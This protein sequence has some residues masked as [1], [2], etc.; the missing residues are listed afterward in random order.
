M[1]KNTAG[2][3]VYVRAID[4]DGAAVTSD[5]AAQI[6]KDG[7]AAASVTATGTHIGNGVWWFALSQAETN[8]DMIS[9]WAES[10]AS[11]EAELTPDP[12]IIQTVT[13]ADFKAT[14]FSTHS[15]A[16]VW[17][18][19][20]RTL[21]SFGTL[22]SDV[23]TAVWSAAAR[24]LTAFGFTVATDTDSRNASK[25]DVSALAL[26]TTAQ[27]VKTQT[28]KI[29]T[30][31]EDVSGLR[32][33]AKALEEAPGGGGDSVWSTGQRDQVLAD[34]AAAK[35]AAEALP[36][37]SAIDTELTASHGAGLWTSSAMG[38]GDTLFTYTVTYSDDVTPIPDVRVLVSTD[39]A[40]DNLIAS[41]VTNNFGE[42]QFQLDAGTYYFWKR[43]AGFAF[44]EVP[45][46]VVVGDSSP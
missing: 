41:G 16:D 21:S 38:S 28:D 2:Q 23:T 42:V 27:A 10:D 14:G 12:V 29:G 5:I 40:R 33:T 35:T 3:G 32:F 26:E 18:V 44:S 34:A 8:A 17:S 39:T 9:V 20:T 30:L 37:A 11:P 25:A 4:T 36:D 22:V 19:S 13:P 1:Y 7:G 46:T 6:T 24:T 15:A 43:K 45:D 31:T